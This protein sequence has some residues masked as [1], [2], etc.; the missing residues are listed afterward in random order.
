MTHDRDATSATTALID[1]LSHDL[2]PVTP[3]A[4]PIW[5]ALGWVLVALGFASAMVW[6]IGVRPDLSDQL[7]DPRF[8]LEQGAA[9]ATG[10]CAAVAALALTIPASPFWLRVLPLLPGTAWVGALGVGCLRDWVD[11]G[12]AGL[13]LSPD[14]ACFFYIALIGSLPALVMALMLRRGAA[15]YPSWSLAAGGLA[16]AAIGNFALRFFHMQDA[17]LMVLV[18]QLGSVLLLAAVSGALGH[19]AL[20][21]SALAP[22]PS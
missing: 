9:L 2:N 4:H 17:A 5:R 11:A 21:R 12:P 18:W 15:L 7:R 8:M 10:F 20:R 22:V 14:M 13:A 6:A 1:Q 3:L 19:W 16:A